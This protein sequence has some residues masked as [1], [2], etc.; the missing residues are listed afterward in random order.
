[1]LAVLFGGRE[2]RLIRDPGW[3]AWGRGDDFTTSG[4]TSAGKTVTNTTALGASVVFGCTTLISDYISTLPLDVLRGVG[5][6]VRSPPAWVEQPSLEVDRV[7]FVGQLLVSLLLVGNGFV[8]VVRNDGGMVSELWALHPDRVRVTRNGQTGR[9]DYTIDG[10][11]FPGQ[12]GRDLLHM[13]ALTWPE[14]PMG[15]SPVEYHRQAVGAALAST[16]FAG[17]FWS[18]GSMPA[19]VIEFPGQV[20]P[21]QAKEIKDAWVRWN[22]GSSRAHLPGVLGGG[23]AW[24]AVSISP[25]QAQFL[26]SRRFTDAQ[27]AA[28]WFRVDPTLIG[29]GVEGQSLTYQNVESRNTHLVRHTLLPWIV[30]LERMF[31]MLLPRPQYAKF[32]VA[33]LLRADLATRYSTYATGIESG[34]LTADE[35]RAYEDLPPLPATITLDV[36]DVEDDIEEQTP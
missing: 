8:A 17:K 26:E 16:E 22:G 3:D 27:I 19:G 33:G 1:M 35:A 21:E 20:T 24:K 5:E 2:E 25:E 11:P 28:Q 14:S 29:V 31:T 32:N 13:R 36:L 7:T 9:L 18:Q 4:N 15:L 10:R 34:F 12:V 23:A 30:R 6:P